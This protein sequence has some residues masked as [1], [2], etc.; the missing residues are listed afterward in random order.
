[1]PFQFTISQKCYID[2]VEGE[3]LREAIK[4]KLF[5]SQW[6]DDALWLMENIL[7]FQ[8]VLAIICVPQ[9]IKRVKNEGNFSG[10]KWSYPECRIVEQSRMDQKDISCKA[11]DLCNINRNPA[12]RTR[13]D[14]ASISSRAVWQ[15]NKAVKYYHTKLFLRGKSSI[16]SYIRIIKMCLSCTTAYDSI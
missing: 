5:S 6:Y 1:M 11:L 13:G 15:P 2:F 7:P 12:G 10:V 8:N 4:M 9:L 3:Y 14:N 16:I